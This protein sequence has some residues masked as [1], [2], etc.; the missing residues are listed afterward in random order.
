M[1]LFKTTKIRYELLPSSNSMERKQMILKLTIKTAYGVP[2]FY[3]ANDTAKLLCKLTMT[4][5]LTEEHL[6]IAKALG[7][8]IEIELAPSIERLIE[9]NEGK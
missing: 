7:L 2:R 6:K 1:A 4:K 3:P 8:R 9:R 5:T